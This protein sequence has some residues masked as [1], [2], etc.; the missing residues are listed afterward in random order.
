[1][2]SDCTPLKKKKKK[3]KN[4]GPKGPN[5]VPKEHVMQ[6]LMSVTKKEYKLRVMKRKTNS[7]WLGF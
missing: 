7:S 3:K 4:Q 1:M 6:I 2:L 5:W